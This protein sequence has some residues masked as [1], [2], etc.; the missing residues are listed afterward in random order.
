[1]LEKIVGLEKMTIHQCQELAKK[2]GY[3]KT[4]FMLCGPK[5]KMKAK[6]LDAHFGFFQVEGNDGI[7]AV[8]QL[9]FNP[10]VWCEDLN[11]ASQSGDSGEAGGTK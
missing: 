10:D 9:A 4:E 1:M 3:D 5:G 7:V 8:Q 2:A 6:W 11:F